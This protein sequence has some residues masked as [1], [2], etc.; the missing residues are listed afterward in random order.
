M[1][2]KDGTAL[3]G[4][5]TGETDGEV[6]LRLPGG[7]AQNVPK[8]DIAKREELEPSLMP[9]GLAAVIGPDGLVDLVSWLQTLK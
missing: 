5:I 7:V 2:K 4:Y 9:P 3:V 1:T 6:Q 8:K